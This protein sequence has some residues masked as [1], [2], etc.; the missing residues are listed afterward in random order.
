MTTMIEHCDEHLDRVKRKCERCDIAYEGPLCEHAYI[1]VLSVSG[2]VDDGETR[3]LCNRHFVQYCHENEILF[4]HQ[5]IP[6][7]EHGIDKNN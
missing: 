5:P 7:G 2:F 1:T 4:N 3:F 6:D